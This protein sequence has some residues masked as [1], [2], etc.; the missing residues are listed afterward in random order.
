MNVC[1]MRFY[2]RKCYMSDLRLPQW[3]VELDCAKLGRKINL[4]KKTASSGKTGQFSR[5]PDLRPLEAEFC[6]APTSQAR[7]TPYI[8]VL[9]L[10]ENLRNFFF[11]NIFKHTYIYIYT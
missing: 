11:L 4:S 8:L 1:M 2:V 7:S 6:D 5:K 9:N 3:L 10:L